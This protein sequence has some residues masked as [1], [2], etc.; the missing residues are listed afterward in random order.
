MCF[1]T[2]ALL[3]LL[4]LDNCIL[5]VT[6]GLITKDDG[7]IEV[8]GELTLRNIT[9]NIGCSCSYFVPIMFQNTNMVEEKKR[10]RR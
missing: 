8:E 1:D 6:Y 9:V 3:S 4:V 2:L 10:R 7:Q 5:Q